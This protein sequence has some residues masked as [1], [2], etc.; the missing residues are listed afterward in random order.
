MRNIGK[1][2]LVG[3]LLCMAVS[4]SSVA[5]DGLDLSIKADLEL[6]YE[7]SEDVSG[8]DDNDKFKSN[9]LYIDFVGKNDAGVEAKLKLDGADI[10]SADG[11]TVSAKV[12]EEANFTL[13]NIGGSP[14]T[15]CF[16]KDEMPFGMDYDKY[17]NDSIAHQFELDKV[18]GANVKVDIPETGSLTVGL[19]QH[20]H[21]LKSGETRMD[22]DNNIGD[23]AT[24][25]L[26]I[27]KLVENL[28][29]VLSC[30]VEAYSSISTNGGVSVSSAKSDETRWSVGF[31]Y[32]VSDRGNINVEY[33][34]FENLKGSA[35]N[36]S[37][38]VTV[39]LEANIIDSLKAFGRWENILDDVATATENNF[40]TIGLAYQPA[41]NYTLSVEYSNFNS[42]DMSD[43]K[44]LKVAKGSI[45]DSVLLGVR[46]KF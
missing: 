37:A 3:M 12:I 8:T 9:Q 33:I 21:S 16:G 42:G 36:S 22:A 27:D 6:F 19:H 28:S 35:G 31:V 46:A 11:K 25:K 2:M 26:K 34:G 1:A 14:I 39:G 13:K 29:F 23:N 5:A 18:W 7:F 20:R 40:Y 10:E 43:A 44:D 30:A 38:L 17:L 32:K 15:V 45:S 41:K 24:A 4:M